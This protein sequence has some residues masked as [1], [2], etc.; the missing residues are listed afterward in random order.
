[1]KWRI[2]DNTSNGTTTLFYRGLRY[3]RRRLIPV[4]IFNENAAWTKE[5]KYLGVMLASKLTY[6]ARI[7]SLL[8]KANCKLRQLFP[9]P[10]KSSTTDVNLTLTIYK[11]LHCSVL[12][13]AY[14]SLLWV[15]AQDCHTHKL[16]TFQN[17]VLRMIAKLPRA[18]P[19]ATLQEQI[20]VSLTNSYIKG[21]ATKLYL[22]PPNSFNCLIQKL[23][24]YDPSN[25]KYLRPRSLLTSSLPPSAAVNTERVNSYLVNGSEGGGCHLVIPNANLESQFHVPHPVHEHI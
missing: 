22:K 2:K 10:N 5:T 1:V 20:A 3:Y 21:L 7:G 15:H 23:G 16:Q 4:R 14:A 12:T 11:A 19:V 6:K 17:K 9:V 13:Y 8:H 25:D 24:H 18:K